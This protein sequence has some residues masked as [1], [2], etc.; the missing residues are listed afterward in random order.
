MFSY[1]HS[2]KRIAC[3][4]QV[5]SPLLRALAFRIKCPCCGMKPSVVANLRICECDGLYSR[6]WR[7]SPNELDRAMYYVA[8]LRARLRGQPETYKAL[9][10]F[11]SSFQRDSKKGRKDVYIKVFKL[12]KNNTDMV[13]E[14][15]QFL[16]ERPHALPAPPSHLQPGT[17]VRSKKQPSNVPSM[18]EAPGA[19]WRGGLLLDQLAIGDGPGMDAYCSAYE[20]LHELY[21]ANPKRLEGGFTP[22]RLMADLLSSFAGNVTVRVLDWFQW[23]IHRGDFRREW[24][25]DKHA[26]VGHPIPSRRR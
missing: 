10:E 16:P 17:R 7:K 20:H 22:E 1:L 19:P 4:P 24:E 5:H 12:L 18:G 13:S 25:K 8:R 11:L 26:R 2:V 15:M 21:M 9:M 3:L 14:F 6:E 23:G